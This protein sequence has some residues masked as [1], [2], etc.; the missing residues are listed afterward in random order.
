MAKDEVPPPRPQST[1]LPRR[2]RARSQDGTSIPGASILRAVGA[3]ASADTNTAITPALVGGAGSRPSVP[4]LPQSA[5]GSAVHTSSSLVPLAGGAESGGGGGGEVCEAAGGGSS[6]DG[7][8]DE[9]GGS[10]ASG[11]GAASLSKAKEST[12]HRGSM[13]GDDFEVNG[14]LLGAEDLPMVGAAGVLMMPPPRKGSAHGQSGGG[15]SAS[16]AREADPADVTMSFFGPSA[17]DFVGWGPDCELEAG[18]PLRLFDDEVADQ[19]FSEYVVREVGGE[20]VSP[21]AEPLS[22]DQMQQVLAL[23]EMAPP[24]PK[25]GPNLLQLARDPKRRDECPTCASEWSTAIRSLGAMSLE[26]P[27]TQNSKGRRESLTS[28]RRAKMHSILCNWKWFQQ[29]LCNSLCNLRF[30]EQGNSRA[31]PTPVI[32]Y[33]PPP[34]HEVWHHWRQKGGTRDRNQDRQA[35]ADRLLR[36]ESVNQ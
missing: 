1:A 27:P 2:P 8:A 7:A 28:G 10:S 22:W 11:R 18:A 35:A 16:H 26:G 4:A 12:S 32:T 17:A 6:A 20:D 15:P 13:A 19:S 9:D 3:V 36:G 30:D 21:E 34:M 14:V 29:N 5:P 31:R 25:D 24:R 23:S 33:M